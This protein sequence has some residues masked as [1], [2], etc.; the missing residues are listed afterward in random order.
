MTI[1]LTWSLLWLLPGL[2]VALAAVGALW[3]FVDDEDH[4]SPV[5]TVVGVA[6]LVA[7]S[8][9]CWLQA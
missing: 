6:A 2:Y 9:A 3:A 4:T 5:M 1:T 8:Y 7:A